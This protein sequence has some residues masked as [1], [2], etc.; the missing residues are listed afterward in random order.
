[1][2]TQLQLSR[3]ITTEL[4]RLQST[5]TR[6]LENF[7]RK[8]IKNSL[9][10]VE[11]IRS[12]YDS[13][14]KNIIRNTV[15][16]SWIYSHQIMEQVLKVKDP[17]FQINISV[18][19]IQGIEAA[20]DKANDQFWKTSGDLKLREGDFFKVNNRSQLIEQEALD[21][22][23]AMIAFGLFATFYAFNTGMFSKRDELGLQIKLR[24]TTRENCVDSKICLPLNGKIMDIGEVLYN[25]P[26]HKHCRCRLIPVL[27]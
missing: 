16:S 11:M 19:D 7:Y 27:V 8:R 6:E 26:L 22:H 15:Q 14:I 23:A 1:M 5:L 3:K 20:T 10:P 2:P 21:V 9:L 13:E 25:P 4:N 17:K 18:P 12:Q 24:F